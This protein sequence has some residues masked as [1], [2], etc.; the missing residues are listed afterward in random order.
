MKEDCFACQDKHVFVK[1]IMET[2]KACMALN[3]ALCERKRNNGKCPFYKTKDEWEQD[4][5]NRHGTTDIN[6][7]VAAYQKTFGG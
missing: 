3:D 6:A 7:V 2:K 1:G 4:M 5:L